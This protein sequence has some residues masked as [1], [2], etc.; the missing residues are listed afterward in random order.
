M[1]LYDA[2]K[3]ISQEKGIS[4]YKIESDLHL[5]NGTLCKWNKSMPAAD[6]L[7]SVASYLSVTTLFLFDEA[8]RINRSNNLPN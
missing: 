8:K 6:K 7:Q 2:I 4:I 5:S 1:E 3:K